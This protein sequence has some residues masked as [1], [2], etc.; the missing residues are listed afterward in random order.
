M[1]QLLK[2]PKRLA[3]IADLIEQGASV[4]DIG[5]DHG[6]LPVYLAQ[7]DIAR[8]IIASDISE[9]SLSSARRTA[10]KY[11]VEDRIKFV[12]A[13]GLDGVEAHEVDTVVIAGIGGENIAGIINDAPWLR[14]RGVRLILQP[15]TKLDTLCYFLRENGYPIRRM[16]LVR[17][18][19]RLYAVILA[20]MEMKTG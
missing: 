7:R 10:V 2:L 13:P 14:E 5:T 11:G 20:G 4:A 6:F 16:E 19:D 15:Q 8:I 1:Q 18:R 9:G 3:S 17:D 12:T